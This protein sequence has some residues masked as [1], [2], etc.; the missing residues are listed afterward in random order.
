MLTELNISSLTTSIANFAL[1]GC[2]ALTNI[3]IP[4]AVTQI[5]ENAFNNCTLLEK[6]NITNIDNWLKINFANEKS[7]PLY[8]AHNLYVNNELLT[9]LNIPENITKINNYIFYSCTSLIKVV[10]GNLLEVIEKS[11]FKDCTN[12]S[13]LNL[14]NSIKE[15]G[16]RAFENCSWL[17]QI[18]IPSSVRSIGGAAFR[19][20]TSYSVVIL[21][22]NLNLTNASSIF[23]LDAVRFYVKYS[24][25][26]D[27]IKNSYNSL[28]KNPDIYMYS[29]KASSSSNKY[30]HYGSNGEIEVWWKIL[31]I[32]E[33][34][35]LFYHFQGK[36][37]INK[38]ESAN[39]WLFLL[40]KYWKQ[41]F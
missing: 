33:G 31:T 18:T 16:E 20:T 15:I 36:E 38:S 37:Y 21:S 25:H 39:C 35:C 40:S 13:S 30:W 27:A 8:Y 19:G 3:E 41:D 11:A 28:K 1:T 7:N 26:V 10:T 9:E 6:V 12:L 4:Q 23:S 22:T 24:M 32:E 2:S 14:G 17:T 29:E 5:G 34:E